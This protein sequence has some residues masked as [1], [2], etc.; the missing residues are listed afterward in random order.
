MRNTFRL[1]RST[2]HPCVCRDRSLHFGIQELNDE[3]VLEDVDLLDCGNGVDPYS[4]ERALQPLVVSG[5]S[6]V[7]S[8]LL[9]A[10]GAFSAGADG[11]G[12]LHEPLLVHL[13]NQPNSRAP[14]VKAGTT[15]TRIY[16]ESG[17]VRFCGEWQSE[18]D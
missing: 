5:S 7:D 12:H 8:L 1:W 18:P 15:G 10:H 11:A 6:L 3:I 9:P 2:D 17:S 16:R 13:R 14:Q 4:L